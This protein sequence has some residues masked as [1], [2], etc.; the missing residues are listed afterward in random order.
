MVISFVDA[1]G[2]HHLPSSLVQALHLGGFSIIFSQPPFRRYVAL[3]VQGSC[4]LFQWKFG[5]PQDAGA[6]GR[7]CMH[8]AMSRLLLFPVGLGVGVKTPEFK[9]LTKRKLLMKYSN[10]HPSHAPVQDSEPWA[11]QGGR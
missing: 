3:F 10:L 7:P 11:L 9:R 4:T 2:S 6:D 5:R 1:Q 8:R